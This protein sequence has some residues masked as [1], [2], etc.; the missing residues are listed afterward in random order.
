MK[1]KS[2]IADCKGNIA[3]SFG[4]LF[5]PMAI[6]AGAAIDVAN[7]N[8]ARS[9][10]QAAADAAALAG[11][12]DLDLSNADLDQMVRNYTI[13]N[14]AT[15]VVTTLDN[16]KT[17]AN[18]KNGT[19]EV[20]VEGKMKTSLMALAGVSE[21]DVGVV[22]AVTIGS[23]ALDLAMV[24]DVTGSME[25][26]IPSGGTRMQA[27]RTAANNLVRVIE[28]EKASYA[29]LKVGVVP[30]AEYVNVGMGPQ[31]QTSG[32]TTNWVGCV[33]SRNTPDD[34]DTSANGAFPIASGVNC[35][36]TPLLPLTSDLGAARAHIDLLTG[37]GN[38]Y[39]PAGIFWGTNILSNDAPFTEGM[40]KVELENKQGQKYMIVMTDGENTISPSYPLHQNADRDEANRLTELACTNAKDQGIQVFTISF[41]VTAAGAQDMLNRCA[42]QP[43]MAFDADNVAQL[44]TAFAQIGQRL[45][46]IRLDK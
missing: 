38:T 46:A 32:D 42:S 4:L 35:P 1:V 9:T 18:R 26:T 36:G 13:A 14:G 10:L 3:L 12:A 45:S 17:T 15:S 28:S 33:G 39:M 31:V 29:T 21:I 24:L 34:V 30:F 40:S 44:D 20:I 43:S 8:H 6:A 2:F 41:M 5:V 27:L 23:R 11:G 25:Q 19:L 22:S 7:A 37:Q 16:I